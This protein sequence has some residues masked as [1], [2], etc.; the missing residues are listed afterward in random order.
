MQVDMN[1]LVGLASVCKTLFLDKRGKESVKP[2]MTSAYPDYRRSLVSQ[3]RRNPTTAGIQR[4]VGTGITGA[5]L[6]A[7]LARVLT[8]KPK[9]VGGAALAGL[10]AGGIPGFLSGREEARSDYTKLLALRRMGI[11]TPAEYEQALAF[12]GIVKK[13][14]AEGYNTGYE[15]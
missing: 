8:D 15:R 13:I 11:Q 2:K 12:P 5:V 1:Q 10:L 9:A 7:L 6:A 4:G 14:T 3:N